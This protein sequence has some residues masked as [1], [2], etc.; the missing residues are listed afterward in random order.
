MCMA[1]FFSLKITERD[2]MAL[3]LVYM[4][5]DCCICVAQYMYNTLS[6][7]IQYNICYIIIKMSSFK[8][9]KNIRKKED[10]PD[11]S[12]CSDIFSV[13]TC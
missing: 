11:R 3:W 12:V 6:I 2:I 13:T 9:S 8:S 10:G 4:Y 5:M 1:V 7:L